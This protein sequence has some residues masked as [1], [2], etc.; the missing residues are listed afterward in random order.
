M[1]LIVQKYGGTS[2][3]DADRIK[4][5]AARVAAAHKAGNQVVVVV[6]AMGKS[7]DDLIALAKQVSDGR[8]PRQ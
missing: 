1:A 3:G 2:V 7:T 6:S 8:H 5:V 4:R